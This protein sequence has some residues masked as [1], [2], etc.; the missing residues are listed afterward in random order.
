MPFS[1]IVMPLYFEAKVSKNVQKNKS[2]LK[3]LN[4]DQEGVRAKAELRI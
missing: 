3:R 2:W 4:V 1:S